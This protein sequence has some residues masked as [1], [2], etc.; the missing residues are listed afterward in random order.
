MMMDIF[1]ELEICLNSLEYSHPLLSHSMPLGE[2][3]G[4]ISQ[5]VC[6]TLLYRSL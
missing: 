1:I 4:L 3:R 5:I 2:D 6:V